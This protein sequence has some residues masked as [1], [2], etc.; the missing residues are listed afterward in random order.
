[1]ETFEKQ[2]SYLMILQIFIKILYVLKW[3]ETDTN[4]LKEFNK[5]LLRSLMRSLSREVLRLQDYS[6]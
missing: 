3:E 5:I 1:M 6:K 2:R 4:F